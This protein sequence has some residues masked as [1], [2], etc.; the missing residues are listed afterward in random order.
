MRTR[1]FKSQFPS[2]QTNSYPPGTTFYRSK[3]QPGFNRKISLKH[4]VSAGERAVPCGLLR[5]LHYQWDSAL[6]NI[7]LPPN[8]ADARHRDYVATNEIRPP[9]MAAVNFLI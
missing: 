6:R 7:T 2:H 1:K 8:A 3:S 5:L 9:S 4:C